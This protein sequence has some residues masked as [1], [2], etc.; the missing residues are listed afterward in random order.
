[1]TKIIGLTGG[2]GSGK[3]T[4]SKLFKKNNIPVYNSDLEA[5]KI[6]SLKRV[7]KK[8]KEKFGDAILADNQINRVALAKIVFNDSNKLKQ[9]NNI[10]HPEVKKHFLKWVEKNKASK[11]VIKEAAV[12]FESESYKNCDIIITVTAPIE[13]RINRV[14]LRDNVS[15]E[16]VLER[17]NNQ[18]SDQD[19]IKLSNF[20]IENL[21]LKETKN[22]IERI[23]ILLNN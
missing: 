2:I 19:K 22:Q 3:T 10:V 12:L 4:V 21:D 16:S 1:M 15:K 7:I 18:W 6:M 14:M 23:L 13:T 9:L 11:F 17:I 20:V 5:K 8:I